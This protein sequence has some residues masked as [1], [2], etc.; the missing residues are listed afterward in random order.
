MLDYSSTATNATSTSTACN[1]PTQSS[2]GD[3]LVM[4][5]GTQKASGSSYTITTPSGWN[6]LDMQDQGVASGMVSGLYW[7]WRG[8]ETSVTVGFSAATYASIQIFCYKGDIDATTPIDAYAMAYDTST[9]G[10]GTRTCPSVTTSTDNCKIAL[11]MDIERTSSI[12]AVINWD[13]P[14]NEIIDGYSG[15]NGDI[16]YSSA[17]T[18]KRT[19]GATGTYGYAPGASSA[20]AFSATVAI[21]PGNTDNR[22]IF[23]D[24]VENLGVNATK[25][26][27]QAYNY[28]ALSQSGDLMILVVSTRGAAGSITPTTPSGWTKLGETDSYALSPGG[29][30]SHL[31]WRIRGAETSV[32]H[33]F[34]SAPSTF[35]QWGVVVA[36]DGASVD[37]TS[38]I[39]D[40]D[41]DIS[42]AGGS[43]S[44]P[45]PTVTT[46]SN[47][48]VILSGTY[49]GNGAVR[50]V[51]W[52]ASAAETGDVCQS[53]NVYRGATD[54]VGFAPAN[55]TTTSYSATISSSSAYREQFWAIAVQPV[56]NQTV[57]ASDSGSGAENAVAN[58][59]VT[60]T[61]SG[62]AAE[63]ASIRVWPQGAIDALS[64]SENAFVSTTLVLTEAANAV[65][66]ASA[67]AI[68][69]QTDAVSGADSAFVINV[70]TGSD[71]GSAAE[72]SRVT[73]R[74]TDT[75]N[76]VDTAVGQARD[77]AAGT[78]TQ[79]I[80]VYDTDAANATEN[81]YASNGAMDFDAG[82]AAD[83]AS[84]MPKG[85]DSGSAT[86]TASTT[87]NVP[88][89][90]VGSGADNAK[91]IIRATTETGNAA[92]TAKV[93]VK[94][95]TDTGSAAETA[96]IHA[97]VYG[98][99]AGSGA[100]LAGIIVSGT[101]LGTS[102]EDAF[103]FV[104]GQILS[105]RVTRIE[106]D[107][108]TTIVERDVRFI[109]VGSQDRRTIIGFEDRRVIK[110]SSETRSVSIGAEA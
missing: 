96:S 70:A 105:A 33:V 61:D 80:T 24:A 42:M 56:Q 90:D 4:F 29:S 37:P 47:N 26:L 77:A 15:T 106:K 68:V 19:A 82:S 62:S 8:A 39:V 48:I 64:G 83:T 23:V 87:A 21:R 75:A 55:N 84:V 5:V 76:A 3:L 32:T 9:T 28:P 69:T 43:T 50:S 85:T 108:R 35:Y 60:Q 92:D 104:S 86:E 18:M 1:Y 63:T 51:V 12:T 30:S 25:T 66:S 103:R 79:R 2:N 7:R 109:Q 20:Q 91:V 100:D 81:A 101:D 107:S 57:P 46:S 110:V 98:S 54:A 14:V 36:I 6:L 34:S 94:P 44:L 13:S 65:D 31:Y 10:V 17:T 58:A 93:V 22:P 73:I 89:T 38:P 16:L 53:I 72:T 74:A 88:A 71:S 11:F 41:F 95:A 102:I 99:E 97:T 67:R 27:S 78:E 45:I 59:V 40:S 49:D 52:D